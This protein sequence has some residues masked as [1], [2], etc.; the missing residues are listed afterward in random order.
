[1]PESRAARELATFWSVE[2][3]RAA[4]LQNLTETQLVE[5]FLSIALQEDHAL[6][7]DEYGKL[8]RLYWQLKA[9]EQELKARVDDQRRML[10]SLFNHPNAQVRLKA[11]LA[12]LAVAPEA[13]RATLQLISDRQEYPQAADARGMMR[14]IDE[15]TYVP[16]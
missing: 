11:A 12:T 8:R 9:V 3:M 7:M 14:A 4:K 10:A 5:R 15:G 6:L 16:T 1:M 13:A 2:T